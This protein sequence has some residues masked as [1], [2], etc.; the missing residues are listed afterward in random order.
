MQMFQ[1]SSSQ[2]DSQNK[3]AL[4]SLTAENETLK[5]SI[6]QLQMQVQNSNSQNMSM[7]KIEQELRNKLGIMSQKMVNQE[8]L[9]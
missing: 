9:M 8:A 3:Q 7:S 5:N 1:S 4:S 2:Q 6:H